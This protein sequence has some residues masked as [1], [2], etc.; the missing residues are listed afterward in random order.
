MVTG[1]TTRMMSATAC[2]SAAYYSGWL[3]MFMAMVADAIFIIIHKMVTDTVIILIYIAMI[4][5]YAV[6][7]SIRE[8]M[9]TTHS[10]AIGIHKAFSDITSPN[11][12]DRLCR[13]G[14]NRRCKYH[15]ANN[16]RN[17]KFFHVH[18]SLIVIIK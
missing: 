3:T 1:M 16:S 10:V 5:A 13:R 15:R 4:V 7:V 9:V 14:T 2:S 6:A 18:T 11:A 17:Q 12:A 8:T